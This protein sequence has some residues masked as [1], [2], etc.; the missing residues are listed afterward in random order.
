[1]KICSGTYIKF[2]TLDFTFSQ[3]PIVFDPAA[4]KEGQC[5]MCYEKA[6]HEATA[7]T[8][9]QTETEVGKLKALVQELGGAHL[10]D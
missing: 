10:L 2:G 6:W 1:M 4:A 7:K 5:P 9:Q 3:Q 8:L